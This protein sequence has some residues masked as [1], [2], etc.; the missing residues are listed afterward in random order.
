MAFAIFYNPA[1]SQA[2][3]DALQSTQLTA[4]ERQYA[5]RLWQGGASGWQSAPPAPSEHACVSVPT[6]PVAERIDPVKIWSQQADGRW[7]V[8][9]P[10]MTVLAL[11]GTGV[12]KQ[13]TADW[14]KQIGSKYPELSYMVAI[15]EDI[16]LTA[17]EPW[18]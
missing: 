17:V 14:L 13:A 9:D 12:T 7:L 15:S 6:E 4:Q 3:A 2:I 11:S 16:L 18:P 1:D 8:C 10:T 5:N